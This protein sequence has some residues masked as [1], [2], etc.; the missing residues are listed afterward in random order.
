MIP[1]YLRSPHLAALWKE[2][3]RRLSTGAAVTAIRLRGLN[4]DE[5]HA[6]AELLGADRLP[7]AECS[8]KLAAVREAILPHTL[9]AAL[10]ELVGPIDNAAQQREKYTAERDA[11]WS[12]LESHPLLTDRPALRG[13]AARLRAE[14]P[15][16]VYSEKRELISR[17]ISVLQS[18]PAERLPLPVLAQ[19]TLGDP[20]ALD[21]GRL[22]SLVLRAIASET[23]AP[24]PTDAEQRRRTWE[25]AG[26]ICDELS[27]TVL[28]AGLAPEGDSLLACILRA[29]RSE[30]QAVPVTL[31]Q[32]RKAPDC[33]AP[34]G[35]VVSVVE[36][37]S[38]MQA[39]LD[40]FGDTVP[41]LICV[42]GRL[43]IAA[44]ILLR[45]LTESGAQLR[46]HGDFDPAGISIAADV[47]GNLGARP[48]H[49]GTADYL[50]ALVP[51]PV[52]DAALVP[53][54]PWDVALQETMR[55][56]RFAVYEEAVIETLLEDLRQ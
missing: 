27:S 8:I 36:N 41:P 42:S 10:A 13:W 23:G 38:I 21:L 17:A 49:M 44:R 31:A 40:R 6:L 52:I 33:F 46:Y 9:E 39:A 34:G 54:T 28:V 22:P 19:R 18:L 7:A 11:L 4:E 30:G 24:V 16:G 3:H 15:I 1:P 50:E 51:G 43:H 48:W 25:S 2:A 29:A 20:H 45:S 35:T 26:I 5:R 56:E 37:P 53:P 47:V 12:W 32:M 14:P 55:R